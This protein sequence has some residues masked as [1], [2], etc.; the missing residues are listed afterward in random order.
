MKDTPLF[1]GW[2]GLFQ[3]SAATIL[4]IALIIG[5]F[6]PAF[7][8]TTIG[9]L[10]GSPP[11]R[12]N[13]HELNQIT[14]AHVPGPLGYVWPGGGLNNYSGVASY[15]PGY[16]SP[17]TT[18]EQP[19]QLA[20]NSY[21][22][23]GAILT[24]TS[25][26]DS[27]GDMIFAVSLNHPSE[28]LK[29]LPNGKND[30]N[31]RTITLYIPAP[32]FDKTGALI[33]DGFEPVKEIDWDGGE[34]T[35]IVTTITDNYGSIFVTRADKND[36]FGPGSWI[37]FISPSNG[38]NFTEAHQWSEWY[39]IRINQMKAPFVAG[40]YFFKVFLNNSYPIRS[41][42]S[43]SPVVATMPME[44]WPV[45]LVK[46]EVD[47]GIIWGTV[48]HGN[49]DNDLLYGRPINLSGRV[50]ASG[51]ALN[52]ITGEL[53]GR[54]VEAHGYFNASAQ[55]HFEIEGVAPGV[56][57]LF[58]S[59]AGYPEQRIA[60]SVKIIRGQSLRL[61]AYL[62]AGPEVRGEVF[63]KEKFG[64]VSWPGQRAVSVV[65]Y[66]SDT[67]DWDSIVTRSPTNLTHAPFTSYAAGNV[68]FDSTGTSLATPN[69]PKKVAF[70]WEGPGGIP[71]V[72]WVGSSSTSDV[73]PKDPFGLF[74]GVGPAQ[75][76]W[77]DPD[78]TY[79]NGGG[80]SSFHFQFG[81]KGSYGVPTKISGMVPQVFATWTDSLSPRRYYVR[82]FV[83][84]YVQS[85]VEGTTLIDYSFA[86]P[87]VGFGRDISLPIDIWRS[88]AVN[89][90]IHFHDLPGT[91]ENSTVK[92][93]DPNRFLIA[94]A[95]G[96]DESLAAFNFTQVSSTDSSISVLLNGLGMAG[97]MK[98][99]PTAILQGGMSR[100]NVK[101]SLAK[102]RNQ[103]KIAIY[104]ESTIPSF[105]YGLY[106]DTYTIRVFMRGFIQALPPATDFNEFD[107]PVATSISIGTS[108]STVSTHMYRGCGINTTVYSV[109][110]QTPPV[111]R[112]WVWNK[113]ST[114]VLVYDV[115]SQTFVDVIYF[116]NA[117]ISQWMIPTQNSET[118]TLPW[119]DWKGVFGPGA[120]YLV[121]NGSTLI[122]RFGPDTP[123]FISIDPSQ[124]MVTT[125]FIQ[126][127]FHVGF[128]Y[129]S[130]TYRT[131]SFRSNLAIYPGVYALNVWTYG[132]VQEN[133]ATLGDLGNVHVSVG[134]LGSQ[135]DANIRVFIGVNFTIT[136]LFKQEGI[137]SEVPFNASVR[138]RVFDE[139]DTLI[140]AATL[141]SDAGTLD[142]SSNSGFFT[143]KLVMDN[144]HKLLRHPIPAG[145]QRL[146]YI[147]LAGV[148]SY[149]EPSTGGAGVQSATLF[150][151]DHGIWG[152]S[153]H[154]GS[155]DGSWM[156]MVD[157]VNW[158][159][160]STFYPP[161]PALLQGES[162]SPTYF[163]YNHLGPFR[164]QGYTSIPNVALG[165][166]ASVVFE[167]DLRSS[168]QGVVYCL[169]WND[170]TRTISW[171]T[172]ELKNSDTTYRWYT[173]DGWFDGYLD[174]GDYQV[175]VSEWT[176][177]NE[178]HN[179]YQFSLNAGT[180]QVNRAFT[181]TLFE[182]GIPIPEF[183]PFSVIAI[184]VVAALAVT[185]FKISSKHNRRS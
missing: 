172:V 119:P 36:P 161:V 81:I 83:N 52:P 34:N 116:W 88:S 154:D 156:I 15:P 138:I 101:Y 65:I 60:E 35:N 51:W 87:D 162:P 120:S 38:I 128:L 179:S 102:Y 153:T 137:F 56:Y 91:I 124:A 178:G 50:R 9:N 106:M 3:R 158:Y 148:F 169:D 26:H 160:H 29:S 182:T 159:S 171:A 166:E 14:Q 43:S 12:E 135:A 105:D 157:F 109:D 44:N 125:I 183:A 126:E 142:P 121:T 64:L 74:N 133:V 174:P 90:T 21:A 185:R 17:F 117:K 68:I 111:Q 122:D 103:A 136:M 123:S 145:T 54:A 177:Q 69:S 18:F 63:S 152:R 59:A 67:Y 84:G 150:S 57:D 176:V 77:I 175:T 92:G 39:Y 76:W 130:D 32:V 53:T 184:S 108:V 49:L 99:D 11:F 30:F 37:V 104:G 113:T 146:D 118:S 96:G 71:A 78:G 163:P 8:H 167:L 129:S 143:D 80:S 10:T 16:Q 165:G 164:Q 107:Q 147:S 180:G 23:E 45:L 94:E 79:T 149:V 132:Y 55:G 22:P 168:V 72:T 144:S 28:A 75:F 170:A 27:V 42:S 2:C 31:Y 151:P 112:N 73:A 62:K 131:S 114:S 24:S 141:S 181:I 40:R 100:V 48:R 1:L 7:A 25:D 61:D 93:P 134:S 110:W 33:Q 155:Y 140:A 85:T 127:N 98:T 66:D 82:V 46:G 97:P 139:G 115:A 19:L 13:D 86:I 89:V 95:F 173:W 5:L 4:T 47:P 58:A 70:L 6:A 20:A 41:S